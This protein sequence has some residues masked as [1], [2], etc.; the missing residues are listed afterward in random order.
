MS[1]DL[2]K[3]KA[4]A[5]ATA[6]SQARAIALLTALVGQTVTQADIDAITNELKTSTD[7]EDAEV[8]KDTPPVPTV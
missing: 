6:A 3:L 1:V 5:D 4:Q 8:A 2:T 7:A